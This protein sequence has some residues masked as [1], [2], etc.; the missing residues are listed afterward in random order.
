[1][2][3]IFA[4]LALSVFATTTMAQTNNLGAASSQVSSPNV[5][6]GSEPAADL[7]GIES[8]DTLSAPVLGGGDTV[9]P[10]VVPNDPLGDNPTNNL[11]IDGNGGNRA[12]SPQSIQ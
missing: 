6:I 9:D 4:A 12:V 1:M 3:R 2:K 11:S 7:S 8:G 10:L 5:G